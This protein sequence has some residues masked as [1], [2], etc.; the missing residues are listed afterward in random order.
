MDS[1]LNITILNTWLK[2]NPPFKWT[3][4]YFYVTNWKK[5]K[6]DINR[7]IVQY[8]ELPQPIFKITH[9]VTRY[10][11][12][13]PIP[14]FNPHLE[15]AI[16]VDVDFLNS[17]KMDD[18]AP[19][20]LKKVLRINLIGQCAQC[21]V[22]R[23]RASICCSQHRHFLLAVDQ[24]NLI[25]GDTLKLITN[26]NADALPIAFPGLLKV[27]DNLFQGLSLVF[28]ML[29][30]FVQGRCNVFTTKGFKQ[31]INA[32]LLKSLKRILVVG[33]GEYDR[34]FERMSTQIIKYISICQMN[35]Q[36]VHL[37]FGMQWT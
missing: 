8:F 18:H 30:V 10:D 29:F 11:N 3:P 37:Y 14:L 19:I 27:L 15:S 36:K 12:G 4:D 6:A 2:A 16:A 7:A 21:G 34:L 5:R 23:I 32:V 17:V 35:I 33:C 31:I 26:F 28:K 20:D 1:S 13:L 24:M 22:Y 9:A 25:N